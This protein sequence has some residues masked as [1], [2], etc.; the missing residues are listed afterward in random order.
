MHMGQPARQ[1]GV[2]V[3][4]SVCPRCKVD[5]LPVADEID[6]GLF[7]LMQQKHTHKLVIAGVQDLGVHRI[8]THWLDQSDDPPAP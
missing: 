6:R 1:S 7:P 2:A 5:M 3:V 8:T 4:T